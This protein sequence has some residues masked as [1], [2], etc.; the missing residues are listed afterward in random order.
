MFDDI[1]KQR[2]N[3]QSQKKVK[4]LSPSEN[5]KFNF[6]SNML[7]LKLMGLHLGN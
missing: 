4:N 6:I 5:F 3:K 7:P 1:M 2:Q